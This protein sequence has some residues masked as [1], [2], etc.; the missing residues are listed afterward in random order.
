MK[1]IFKI[2]SALLLM[3]T[4][5]MNASAQDCVIENLGYNLNKTNLTATVIGYFKEKLDNYDRPFIIITVTIPEK[6]TY[7]GK[8]YKVASIADDAFFNHGDI[9]SITIPNSI[10]SIGKEAFS[11]CN[12]ISTITL[13]NRL[14][15]IGKHA[16]SDCNSLTSITIPKSVTSIGDGAFSGCGLTTII[17]EKTNPNYND[18]KGSNCI[19]ETKT[20]KLI[21]GS[22]KTVVPKGVTSIE[23]GA[24][25]ACAELASLSIPNSVASIEKRAFQ[26]CTS[27]TSLNIPTNV[28]EIKD[29]TFK[30]CHSL[31]SISIPD[32]V[33]SIEKNAFKGCAELTSVKVD[34]NNPVFSDGNGSNCII[35]KKTNSLVL[36]CRNTTIPNSV[37]TIDDNAFDGCKGLTSITIPNNVTSIGD[38]AFANCI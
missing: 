1:H 27:L 21:A 28:T 34:E 12:R 31:T 19:I 26:E 5:S 29:E 14:T 11:Q 37:T 6:I 7:Q 10:T 23:E 15:T 35:D 9:G 22:N 38:H 18:G 20:N 24:F 8:E 36:G 4:L 32:K 33:A 13:P 3:Q 2:L 16:F 17:V 30:D 25:S